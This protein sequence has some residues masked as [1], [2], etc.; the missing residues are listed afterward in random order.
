M[1]YSYE[2]DKTEKDEE[3]EKEFKPEKPEEL[4]VDMFEDFGNELEQCYR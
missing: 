4:D 3:F 2:S 1:S